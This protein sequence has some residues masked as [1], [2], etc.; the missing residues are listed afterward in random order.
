[1]TGL[2]SW[3]ESLGPPER[4]FGHTVQHRGSGIS[5]DIR[6]VSQVSGS[7]EEVSKVTGWTFRIR[8]KGRV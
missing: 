1:M 2:N 4:T 3:G 6:I 5:L 7:L 8:V